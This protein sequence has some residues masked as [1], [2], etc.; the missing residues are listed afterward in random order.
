MAY[1][2]TRSVYVWIAAIP[3]LLL[4]AS[5]WSRARYR[6][7]IRLVDH[8]R[9][10]QATLQELLATLYDAETGRRGF[11][12]NGNPS[13]L[14]AVE[15]AAEKVPA[16]VHR[17]AELTGDN[18]VQRTNLHRLEGLTNARLALLT[19][20]SHLGRAGQ[21]EAVK[22]LELQRGLDASNQLSQVIAQTMAEENRLLELRRR[23]TATADS[24][25]NTLLVAGCVATIILL[26][27]AYRIVSR[28]ARNREIAEDEL[29]TANQQLVEKVGQLD[30]LNQEL[31]DRVKERT[32]SLERS[33]H[34]LQQFA[35]VA[36]HD[37]QEPLRMIVS[38]LELLQEAC[39]GQLDI[40]A[41]KHL[42][43]AVDGA[44]RMRALIRDILIYAQVGS[45]QPALTLTP[46]NEIVGQARYSLLASIRETGAEITSG[47]LP[48]LEVD[49]LQMSLVFQNL[50]SNAIKF[51][52][53]NGR[54]S[55]HVEARREGSEWRISVRDLGIGFDPKFA[56]KIF[57]AFQRLHA[58]G[59]YPGTG[60]GLAIT[61]R[62]I[63]GHGGR[64]WAEP[65]PDAGATF[66][67]TLPAQS[68]E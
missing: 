39:K 54:P 65:N 14:T 42:S 4:G 24:A 32:A 2:R 22:N 55:I 16:M 63:L 48:N 18:P 61:K 67:F 36:S 23:A 47:V 38:H 60:I 57:I 10:V 52:Q 50:L 46:L 19:Q 51:R 62:I 8:T 56:D 21:D 5:V 15:R 49:P 35:F 43:F 7:N 13:Y 45:Q 44:T 6:D 59:A 40:Q 33:N 34:D 31:E 41:E 68:D 20:T 26:L 29:R 58:R 64:I 28:F 37:M 9:E 3:I 11:I 12:L 53:P 17:V 25:A 1:R 66:H 27:W 30:R